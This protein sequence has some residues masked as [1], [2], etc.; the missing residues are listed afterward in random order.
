M[1][2]GNSNLGPS[3]LQSAALSVAPQQLL[4]LQLLTAHYK[5]YRIVDRIHHKTAGILN[6]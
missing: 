3:E 6:F 5:E 1:S 2:Y 4:M